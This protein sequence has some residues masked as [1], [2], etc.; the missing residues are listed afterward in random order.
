LDPE[1]DRRERGD[2]RA[3]NGKSPNWIFF[4]NVWHSGFDIF[5]NCYKGN[6]KR[7]GIKVYETLL[8]L[9]MTQFGFLKNFEKKRENRQIGFFFMSG[10]RGSIFFKIPAKKIEKEVVKIYDT[11]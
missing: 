9:P 4:E 11:F 1:K 6:R 5:Q 7:S 3:K 10:T 2:F 8:K